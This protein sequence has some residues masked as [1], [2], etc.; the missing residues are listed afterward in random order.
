MTFMLKHLD[1][2]VTY[3][4]AKYE[5]NRSWDSEVMAWKH[6]HTDRQKY[7]QADRQMDRQLE[8]RHV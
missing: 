7:R 3:L 8:V 4:H 5:I 2:V 6:R 1:M